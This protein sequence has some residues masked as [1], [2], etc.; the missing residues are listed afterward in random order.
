MNNLWIFG[1][2]FSEDVKNIP[3]K[4]CGRWEY[5][6]KYLNGNPYK[7]WGELLAEKLGLTYR[8]HAASGGYNF[9]HM[10]F[11]NSND[12]I[13]ANSSY[14]SKYFKKDD[15]VIIGLTSIHR[16]SW[17]IDEGPFMVLPNLYP[18]NVDT[19]ILDSILVQRENN[20]YYEQIITQLLLLK[21]LSKSIGFKLFF[22]S[23]EGEF[24]KFIQ[25]N[26]LPQDNWILMKR[27]PPE[28]H[29]LLDPNKSLTIYSKTNGEIHDYHNSKEGELAHSKLF[30]ELIE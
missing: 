21:S 23:W 19:N 2:S 6:N 16:F 11:G 10:G 14:Y 22:W 25:K 3:L 4:N 5:I 27:T 15:I 12:Y 13:I 29:W 9:S 20:F 28:Y 8:N 26:K 24:E 30:F 18:P 17:I 7:S 1:D